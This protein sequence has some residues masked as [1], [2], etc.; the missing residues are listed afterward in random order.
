MSMDSDLPAFSVF[1]V[2]FERMWLFLEAGDKECA[3]GMKEG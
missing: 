1:Y 2:D 3:N